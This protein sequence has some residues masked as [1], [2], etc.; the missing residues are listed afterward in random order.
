MGTALEFWIHNS[1]LQAA[2]TLCMTKEKVKNLYEGDA[3][4]TLPPG[5]SIWIGPFLQHKYGARKAVFS[6]YIHHRSIRFQKAFFWRLRAHI[7]PGTRN[8]GLEMR[9][10]H[11]ICTE[12]K[13]YYHLNAYFCKCEEG[14]PKA[15]CSRDTFC[16]VLSESWCDSLNQALMDT[17][18]M[19]KQIHF[20][21]KSG[22]G[23]PAFTSK[24]IG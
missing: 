11:S 23:T 10:E 3:R 7:W 12:F 6:I 2:F 8:D 17:K 1:F 19:Q 22:C 15:K 20:C 24:S 18:L 5:N 14:W 9:H 4:F 21:R 13:K 16:A